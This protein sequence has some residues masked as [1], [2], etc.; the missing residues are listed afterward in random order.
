MQQVFTMHRKLQYYYCKECS[1]Q[2]I[3]AA[4]LQCKIKYQVYYTA[5]MLLLAEKLERYG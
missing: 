5:F 2:L 3:S 1:P 4:A